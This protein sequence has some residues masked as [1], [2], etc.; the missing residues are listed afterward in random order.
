MAVCG[1]PVANTSLVPVIMADDAT[2]KNEEWTME[3]LQPLQGREFLSWL[4]RRKLIPN[5]V[6]CPTGKW[7]P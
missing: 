2:M 4:T 1:R 3:N 7:Q 6:V 5:S